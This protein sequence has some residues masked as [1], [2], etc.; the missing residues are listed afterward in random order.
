MALED[1][2]SSSDAVS[3]HVP[4]APGA[5]PLIG[6]E[7]IALMKPGALL[8]NLARASLVDL[9][10]M[11]A[12]LRSGRL[13]GAAWDVW[14]RGAAG[15]PADERLMTLRDCS[16]PRTSAGPH[17]RPTSPT[18]PRR[19]PPCAPRWCS[20]SPPGLVGGPQPS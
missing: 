16:S 4:G 3:L 6:A 15:P 19:S 2:L 13:A 20:P 10:A 12:A 9:D 17:R 5:P 1:L 11:L 8:L 14:P 18:R 7:E